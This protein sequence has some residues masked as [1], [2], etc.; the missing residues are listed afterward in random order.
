MIENLPEPFRGGLETSNLW[1]KE[2]R[3]GGLPVTNC[4]SMYLPKTA[5][6]DALCLIRVGYHHGFQISDLFGLGEP[7]NP[8][9]GGAD[10]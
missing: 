8:A 10:G 3:E 9:Q 7:D 2:T 1:K 6:K 4:L 5:N